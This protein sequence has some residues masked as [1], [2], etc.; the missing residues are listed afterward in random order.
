MANLTITLD[1]ALLKRAR[2]RASEQGTSVNSLVRGYLT[3]LA[4]GSPLKQQ[5]MHEVI[6][7]ARQSQAGSGAQGRT[8]KREDLYDR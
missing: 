4:G 1:D 8:W 2:I 5:A 7:L 6:S 3:T